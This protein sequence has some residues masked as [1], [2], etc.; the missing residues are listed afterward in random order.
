MFLHQC[1][2][3][4]FAPIQNSRKIYISI[5]FQIVSWKTKILNRVGQWIQSALI[6]FRPFI[7]GT[8]N[9]L[10]FDILLAE[11]TYPHRVLV[12]LF[13]LKLKLSPHSACLA[14]TSKSKL[15]AFRY[16]CHATIVW[17]TNCTTSDKYSALPIA[18]LPPRSCL[19][20][21]P[22]HLFERHHS[23]NTADVAGTLNDVR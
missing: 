23:G 14:R 10:P 17:F 3:P 9:Y 20:L 12:I 13:L 19:Q 18:S 2:R 16:Y 21:V 4:S 6:F 11:V 5:Y 7:F 15:T 8:L 22:R 1:Q